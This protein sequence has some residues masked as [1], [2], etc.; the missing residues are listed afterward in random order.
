MAYSDKE[1]LD[2]IRLGKDTK[3]LDYLYRI[4]AGKVRQM[5]CKHNGSAQEAKDIFQETMMVFYK[6]VK[7]DR[8]N[9]QYSIGA[10]F[11]TVSRNLW[12]NHLKREN[13]KIEFTDKEAKLMLLEENMESELIGKEREAQIV[14]LFA[15]L[16]DRCQELLVNTIFHR[17]TMKE[18]CEKMGYSTEDAAKTKHYKCKQRLLELVG[19][20]QHFKSLL[21]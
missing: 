4:E 20:E 18:I 1:I 10:F 3:V 7:T 16:G 13:R 11:N 17:F 9:E 19:D 2:N 6:Y 8:F 12:I 5:V 15:R 14:A 21:R